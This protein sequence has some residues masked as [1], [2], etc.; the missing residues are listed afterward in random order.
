MERHT[1]KICLHR[2]A[3]VLCLVISTTASAQNQEE[4][5]P[6][7]I[8]DIRQAY[9]QLEYARTVE[10]TERYLQAHPRIPKEALLRILQYRAF[11]Q[12]A[13]GNEEEA[14]NTLRSILVSEPDFRLD[15]QIASPKVVQ[16]FESLKT[17]TLNGEADSEFV[18]SVV[19]AE[20]VQA[21]AMLRSV[22]FPGLGQTYLRKKRGFAY[23][24][25]AATSLGLTVYSAVRVPRLHDR[26]LQATSPS[27]IEDRYDQFNRWYQVLNS[28]AVIYG[29][30][31]G[32]ALADLVVFRDTNS[33]AF[34][35]LPVGDGIQLHATYTW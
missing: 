2:A 10:M 35:F 19:I 14:R 7:T 30:T 12:V 20:D 24:G 9:Q 22:V 5:A 17:E 27:I 23:I 16:L 6:T 21:T 4:K 29:I 18:P 33:P 26:Y 3:I 15:R 32:I 25:I 1:F 28:A 11:S 13:L 34:A 8:E 31:W